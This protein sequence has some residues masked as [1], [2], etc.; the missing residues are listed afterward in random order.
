MKDQEHGRRRP[1]TCDISLKLPLDRLR[2][3]LL[4]FFKRC[5]TYLGSHLSSSTSYQDRRS[6]LIGTFATP[7]TKVTPDELLRLR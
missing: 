3:S 7:P 1:R 6:L 2:V 5:L 4:S